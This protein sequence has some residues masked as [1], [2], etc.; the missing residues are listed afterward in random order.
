MRSEIASSSPM[1]SPPAR[2]GCLPRRLDH[3]RYR[4][5]ISLRVSFA[6]RATRRLSRVES[7]ASSSPTVVTCTV[8]NADTARALSPAALSAVVASAFSAT[9]WSISGVGA[10]STTSKMLR[11]ARNMSSAVSGRCSEC[12]DSAAEKNLTIVG[13]RVGSK[14]VCLIVTSSSTVAGLALGSAP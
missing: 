14:M 2:G 4:V 5:V 3:S 7:N 11:Q 12:R 10:V 1:S 9:D 8:A 6:S 13:A